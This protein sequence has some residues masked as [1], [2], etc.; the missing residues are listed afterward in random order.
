[1]FQTKT[2]DVIRRRRRHSS[3]DRETWSRKVEYFFAG[4]GYAVGLGNIWRFPYL[5]YR[6]GGGKRDRPCNYVGRCFE[7]SFVSNVLNP[8]VGIYVGLWKVVSSDGADNK[9]L[10]KSKSII[11]LNSSWCSNK[12]IFDLCQFW[13]NWF[14]ILHTYCC[15]VL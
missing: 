13:I 10:Q 6:N 12:T 9:Y 5:C 7:F 11:Y 3:G 14:L 4:L 15:A 1:M 8:C 2:N